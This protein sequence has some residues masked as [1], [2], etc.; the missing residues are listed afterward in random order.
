M[1]KGKKEGE[2][3]WAGRSGEELAELQRVGATGP[4]APTLLGST[5]ATVLSGFG[6]SLQC[7]LNINVHM[8]HW[9]SD[10]GGV[11]GS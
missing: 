5:E 6:V 1:L 2:E 10:S 7:F 11:G 8:N 9:V 3:G 4:Q